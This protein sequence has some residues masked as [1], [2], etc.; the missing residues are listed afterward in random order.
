MDLFKRK[1][2]KRPQ[3]LSTVDEEDAEQLK[4]VV[5]AEEQVANI[6]EQLDEIEKQI[7]D[8]EDDPDKAFGK[9]KKGKQQRFEN[10]KGYI[11]WLEEE[12]KSLREEKNA[13]MNIEAG[14]TQLYAKVKKQKMMMWKVDGI[15]R[16]SKIISGVRALVYQYASENT[17]AVLDPDS[18]T[19]SS[20]S[21]SSTSEAPRS[22]SLRNGIY[23]EGNDLHFNIIFYSAESAANF[24]KKLGEVSLIVPILDCQAPQSIEQPI[25]LFQIHSADYNSDD[26]DS[27]VFSQIPSSTATNAA[28]N[29]SITL[30]QSIELPSLLTIGLDLEKAHLV[31]DSELKARRNKGDKKDGRDDANN[32]RLV[33]KTMP[34]RPKSDKKNTVAPNLAAQDCFDR[35]Q[36]EPEFI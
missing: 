31:H 23:Y 16:G 21:S 33:L 15:T 9:L 17:G 5:Q 27:P 3:A 19:S 29:E 10:P 32:N 12:R 7:E 25:R 26:E 18:A 34:H 30:Y 4:K 8:W 11:T 36:A 35:R 14:R 24:I 2:S 13:A 1:S 20:S 22:N 28:P 6:R